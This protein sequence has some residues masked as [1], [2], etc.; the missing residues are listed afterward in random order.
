MSR[1]GKSQQRKVETS[2]EVG[3]DNV[4]ALGLDVHNPV[5]AIAAGTVILF[6][7]VSLLF[8][9]EA[10]EVFSSARNWTTTQLDWLFIISANIFVLLCAFLIFSPLGRVRIGGVDAR[11][12]YSYPSWFAMMFAAGVG[13][14]LMFYGVLEPV[15]HSLNP[16]LGIEAGSA[17]VADGVGVVAA[18]YHWG[19]HAWGIYAVVGLALAIFHYN[20][21]LPLTMRSAFYP[22]LGERIW[23]WPGHV[24]DIL[25]VFATLFG[26]A[27]SLGLGAQQ[28]SAGLNYLFDIPNDDATQVFVIIGITAIALF[29]VV[30]GMD[31]GVKLLSE[32]NMLMAMILMLFVIA[33]GPTLAILEGVV[34]NTIQYV[35]YIP[36]LSNWVG[37]TDQA[38]L[39]DWTTFYWAWWVAWSP[40]VGMFIA[41]VSHGR[42]VREFL[43][44]T[45]LVPTTVGL[46]WMTTFGGAA[47]DQYLS[48]DYTG[49]ADAVRNSEIELALFKFLEVLPLPG[50]TSALGIVL[51]IVFF[52]T[53]MDSGSLVIDTITAGGKID[54]PVAQRIFWCSFEGLVAIALMLGGGLAA[55]QAASLTTGFPFVLVL[56]VMCVSLM[57]GLSDEVH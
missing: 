34:K 40:F 11:C 7:I 23:G 21:G 15:T 19:L 16:P 37:R 51:V 53:S 54:A 55:L 50:V 35:S 6:V 31:K 56:L 8:Q 57:Q 43:V 17:A 27:T 48:G 52:V 29:S 2:Y 26:L 32:I 47:I 44:A 4:Q 42:T 18:V 9:T 24:I 25:A 20:K 41:R 3:Q 14:G 45:L 49:V 1:G 38:F 33:V 13:I 36:A 12:H 10:G 22:L 39:H 30:R 28:T 5:F 46:I